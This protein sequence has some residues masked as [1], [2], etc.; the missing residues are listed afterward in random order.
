MSIERIVVNK[1]NLWL[2]H[3]ELKWLFEHIKE[4]QDDF[5]G[6]PYMEKLV[7]VYNDLDSDLDHLKNEMQEVKNDLEKLQ[8]GE[9]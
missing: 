4:Y 2:N 3:T 7:S 9:M 6:S 1:E 5:D 8:E